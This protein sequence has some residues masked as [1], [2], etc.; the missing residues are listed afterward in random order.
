MGAHGK[1]LAQDGKH[2]LEGGQHLPKDGKHLPEGGQHLPEGG[3][4]LPKDG[5]H[6]DGKHLDRRP[7]QLVVN[8]RRRDGVGVLPVKTIRGSNPGIQ[9]YP[10]SHPYIDCLLD[11]TV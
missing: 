1:N 9:S 4:H 5:K 10:S 2:V 6:L 3:Q 8:P 11:P 7:P